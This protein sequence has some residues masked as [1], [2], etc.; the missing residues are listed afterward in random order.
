L[1]QLKEKEKN[2]EKSEAKEIKPDT[3]KPTT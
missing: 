1:E 3:D 2:K